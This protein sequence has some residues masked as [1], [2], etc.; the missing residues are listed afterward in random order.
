MYLNRNL[1]EKFM[2]PNDIQMIHEY[3]LKV[4]GEIGIIFES[5]RALEVFKQHGARVDGETVYISEQL[6]HEALKTAPSEFELFAL[7]NS[8]KIG[9]RYEPVTV[10]NPRQISGSTGVSVIFLNFCCCAL[11]S[12][13]FFISLFFLPLLYHFPKRFA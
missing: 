10:G 7:D 12:S 1:H 11:S 6:L 2:S 3:T 8:V 9:K 4:L 5:E 13:T